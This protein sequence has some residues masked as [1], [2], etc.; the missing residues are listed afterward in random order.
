MKSMNKKIQ[1]EITKYRGLRTVGLAGVNIARKSSREYYVHQV[2][3]ERV[4]ENCFNLH[5]RD[6]TLKRLRHL[7]T[8]HEQIYLC[9]NSINKFF[10]YPIL[11]IIINCIIEMIVNPWLLITRSPSIQRDKWMMIIWI[12][13]RAIQLILLVE[14]IHGVLAE[15]SK[16]NL[17]IVQLMKEADDGPV[18]RQI[19]LFSM[20]NQI[21]NIEFTSVDMISLH[22]SIYAAVTSAVTTYLVILIQ[23]NK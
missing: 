23:F 19:E 9:V 20:Q 17:F 14:P 3:D 7:M 8:V 22:R 5:R 2:I 21:C 6:A 4:E 16:T 11:L 12:A 10:D 1:M 13:L 18:R 15:H